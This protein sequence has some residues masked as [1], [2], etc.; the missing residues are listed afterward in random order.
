MK[1]S[2]LPLIGRAPL[3]ENID[4]ERKRIKYIFNNMESKLN[5]TRVDKE[6]EY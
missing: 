2:S 1:G 6:I 3:S 5:L 4:T